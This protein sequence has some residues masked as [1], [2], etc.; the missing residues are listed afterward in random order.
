MTCERCAVFDSYPLL[1]PLFF[2]LDAETAHRAAVKAL[3]LG[4]T[5]D[6]RKPADPLLAQD[7]WGK[8]FANPVGLAAGFDKNAETLPHV[9]KLGFGFVEAGSVTPKPQIGNPK[10]RVFRLPEQ[11]A[12]I[13]RYG[14]N[15]EGLDAFLARVKAWRAAGNRDVLGIN[16]SPNKD[17]VDG[18]RDYVT[19][20]TALASYADYLVMN[21]SSPNTPGLRGLQNRAEL[22]QLLAT[23]VAARDACAK[24]PP[25]L[26]KIAPDLTDDMAADIAEVVLAARL[27]G[28]VVSNTTVARPADL[29]ERFKSETGGLS[30]LPLRAPATEVLRKMYRLTDGKLPLIGV[31]GIASGADAYARIRAGASL[32]QLY[33]ALVYDGPALITRIHHDLAA[34][35]RRDGFTCL[36]DAVGAD[37]RATPAGGAA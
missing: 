26:V 6:W 20:I 5:A 15:N 32:V 18:P 17:A 30:G 28:M 8:R 19:G 35:L 11:R 12:V 33:T 10:P 9:F 16:V 14:M 4:L 25:L 31:G 36:A 1:R 3:A 13:N 27:D 21:I 7:L 2:T 23:A 24:R 22:T 37:H 29:P 34:C